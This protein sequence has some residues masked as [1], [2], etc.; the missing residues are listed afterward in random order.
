MTRPDLELRTPRLV[1][2][3]WRDSDRAPFAEL[4]TDPDVME[5]IGTPLTREQSDEWVD[6]IE[7]AF[8][9]RRFGLWAVEVSGGPPFVGFV[10]LSVPSFDAAFT[11]CIEVG[12]RLSR[13]AW[14]HGYATEAAGAAVADGLDRLGLDEIVSFTAVI[15]VRSQRVMQRLGMTRDPADDFDH[16]RMPVGHALRPHVLY[17]LR[18]P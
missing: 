16:P 5:F 8:S 14:G 12:W 10:G 15:N 3:R 2:R 17:R 9:S 6:R 13:A 11:P 1:L 7:E 18:R 4:N